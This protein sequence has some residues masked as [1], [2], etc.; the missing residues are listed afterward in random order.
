MIKIQ[1][2]EETDRSIHRMQSVR[3]NLEFLGERP[4][5]SFSADYEAGDRRLLL[6]TFLAGI[7]FGAGFVW[8]MLTL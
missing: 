5:L 4:E 2:N 1:I 3:D 6:I 8:G 7:L